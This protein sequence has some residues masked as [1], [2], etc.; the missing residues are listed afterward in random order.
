M[1]TSDIFWTPAELAANGEDPRLKII[2]VRSG[3]HY[4]MGHIPRANH[5]SIY[6]LNTYD[7]DEAPLRSFVHMWAFLLGRCGVSAEDRVVFYEDDSGMTAARG[8]WFLEYLGHENVHIL[9]GGLGAWREAGFEL[10]RDAE[11]AT[12]VAYDYRE[13]RRRL[14]T[15][16]DMLSAIDDPT[17][18]VWDTRGDGEWFGT[19]RRA[20]RGGTLPGATHFEWS[21]LLAPDG[22]FK[23]VE[24]IEALCTERGLT[25]DLEVLALCNTGYR[26]AHGYVALRLADYPRVRNYLGSWQEWGNREELPVVI[27]DNGD[28]APMC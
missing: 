5:F 24:E 17:K 11:P 9:D 3:E 25:R 26:S 6:G 2:D 18:V 14:A 10:T 23:T 22:R 27:P 28:R 19:D 16:R 20:K 12:P 8:F 15:Y 1:P 7:T 4:A 21:H 13:T